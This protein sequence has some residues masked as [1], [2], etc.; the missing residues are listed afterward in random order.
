MAR[1]ITRNQKIA[2]EK[3]KKMIEEK[4]LKALNPK[5]F[6]LM[7]DDLS[8][9]IISEKRINKKDIIVIPAK[10]LKKELEI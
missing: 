2:I 3:L 9:F 6:I 5:H 8:S 1:K 4:D 7:H 10:T